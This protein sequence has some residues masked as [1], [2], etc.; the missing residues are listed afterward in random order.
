[1]DEILY[2]IPPLSVGDCFYIAERYKNE[3]NYPIHRHKELEINFVQGGAGA[4]RVVGDSVETIGNLD[5]AMI[6][7]EDLEHAWNQG[8]CKN[9]NIREITIQF[10]KSLL[11]EELLSKNQFATINTM[12]KKAQNG[13]AF[14]PESI[15]KAYHYLDKLTATKDGFEQLQ[16]MLS[17]LYVLSHG[18][19]K[20]LA[21]NTFARMEK[22]SDSRRIQKVKEY[23]SANCSRELTLGEIA[24]VAGMSPSSFSR[25]FKTATGKTLTSYILEIRLGVAA[26]SLVNTT[27]TIAEICYSSGFNNVSNFNRLFK[28]SKGITPK[29]FRQI[30]K[31]HSVIV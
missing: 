14:P 10:D 18:E 27:N 28:K 3:F 7:S 21:S 17:L 19:C 1:M 22:S 25:F 29:E 12:L 30:Y 9:K 13:I 23:V 2:E 31:K 6:G 20:V 11:P 24:G 4:Q 5:L 15:M 16:M 8:Q 26:R